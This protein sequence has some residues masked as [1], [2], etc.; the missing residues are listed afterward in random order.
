MVF[1]LPPKSIKATG[2]LNEEGCDLSMEAELIYSNDA[3]AK[4]KTSAEETLG[5]KAVIVGTKGQI[6]VRYD[7]CILLIVYILT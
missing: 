6:T 2:K 4:I 5:N 1:V 7:S 3:I